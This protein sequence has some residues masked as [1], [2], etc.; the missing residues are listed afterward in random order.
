MVKG[1][2]RTNDGELVFIECT[3]DLVKL[4]KTRISYEAG[5]MIEDL[6]KEADDTKQRIESDL[7]SYESQLDSQQNSFRDIED[8]ATELMW[9]LGEKRIDRNAMEKRVQKILT[10]VSNHI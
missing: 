4:V 3:E 5:H 8:A 9:S 2:F 10:E 1:M 7:E 6:A